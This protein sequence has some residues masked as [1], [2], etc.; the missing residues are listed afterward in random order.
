MSSA[1]FSIRASVG[2]PKTFPPSW[3]VLV[4][5]QTL[6]LNEAEVKDIREA[7]KA[8]G[9]MIDDFL[10]GDLQ[11]MAKDGELLKKL[12]T[13]SSLEAAF[14]YERQLLVGEQERVEIGS[15]VPE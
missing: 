9:L 2:R 8:I 12:E 14:S 4:L 11:E 7:V 5:Q 6:D 3:G 1:P 15:V 10:S 13:A